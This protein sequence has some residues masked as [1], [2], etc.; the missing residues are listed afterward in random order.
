MVKNPLAIAEA[1]GDMGSISGS[2][3]SPGG[4]NGN[5]LQYSYLKN[6][7]GRGVWR[8]T[9]HAGLPSMGSQRVRHN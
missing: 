1:E 5:P 6:R 2:E 9:V 4:R 8:A 3:R 7:M